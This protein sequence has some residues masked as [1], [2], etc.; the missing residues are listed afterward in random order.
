[1]ALVSL[2]HS[3]SYRDTEKSSTNI[4]SSIYLKNTLSFFA[5]V[6]SLH[7]PWLVLALATRSVQV[8][9]LRLSQLYFTLYLLL[10]YLTSD[11]LISRLRFSNLNYA[12]QMT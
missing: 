1:M 7:L 12:A 2:R 5:S 4:L 9:A 6:F 10:Q 11:T 3:C 8:G